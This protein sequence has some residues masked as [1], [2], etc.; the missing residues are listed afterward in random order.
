MS[1]KTGFA[2]AQS[3]TEVRF[4]PSDGE[5]FSQGAALNPAI[6]SNVRPPSPS[7]SFLGRRSRRIA[8]LR[9]VRRRVDYADP[10]GN[11]RYVR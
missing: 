4:G 2:A 6:I 3:A 10:I 8:V 1:F 11:V 9:S 7:P 5:Q